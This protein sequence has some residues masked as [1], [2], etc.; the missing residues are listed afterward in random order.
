MVVLEIFVGC[1]RNIWGW[2]WR[3]LVDV[4]DIYCRCR[5]DIWSVSW[6]YLM[7]VLKICGQSWR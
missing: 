5:G 4:L 6:R 3:Y 2:S 1:Y 7:G